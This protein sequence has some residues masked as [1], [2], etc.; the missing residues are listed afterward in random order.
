MCGP[1]PSRH[2]LQASKDVVHIK[3]VFEAPQSEIPV[4][5]GGKVLKKRMRS[6]THRGDLRALKKINDCMVLTHNV[7]QILHD[8]AISLFDSSFIVG[9]F[10]L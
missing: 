6:L 4:W 7:M 5:Q 3:V 9:G 2:S 1:L 10:S 8:K